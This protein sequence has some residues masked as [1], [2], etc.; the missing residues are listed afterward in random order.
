[1]PKTCQTTFC[2]ASGIIGCRQDGDH[3]SPLE[4]ED[5][6]GIS[7]IMIPRAPGVHIL[8]FPMDGKQS[9]LSKL[10]P[11]D[12]AIK[13]LL[14]FMTPHENTHYDKIMQSAL[15]RQ[16]SNVALGGAFVDRSESGCG[17]C[18]AF[19]GD[20]VEA[21]SIVI[22]PKDKEAEI[23]SKLKLFQETGLM[24]DKCFAFM[25]ACVARGYYLYKKYNVESLIFNKMY[26]DV[27][28]LGVFGNGEIG[29]DYLPNIPSDHQVL[30]IGKLVR[31]RK[32]Y[33]HSYTTIFVLISL[34]L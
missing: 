5:G 9:D 26:P 27:P 4:I 23:E 21:A 29:M 11:S 18:V 34:K 24:K 10:I 8:K 22:K 30:R 13:C 6:Y 2:A 33:L 32:K 25:F 3:F 19:C 14:V 12:L 15:L 28:L 7:G 1:M 20:G 17:S 31:A 16:N